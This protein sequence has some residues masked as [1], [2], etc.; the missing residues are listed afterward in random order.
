MSH[1]KPFER[2]NR[3][4]V[5]KLSDIRVAE[6]E[7]WITPGEVGVLNAI[8]GKIAFYR[9]G[10]SKPELGCVVVEND[11]PEYELVWAMLEARVRSQTCISAASD[12]CHSRAVLELQKLVGLLKQENPVEGSAPTNCPECGAAPGDCSMYC[13]HVNSPRQKQ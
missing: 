8:A 11:W 2:E 5:L 10:V 3:Y 7:N 13:S 1:E 9:Y 4:L 12:A 6:R